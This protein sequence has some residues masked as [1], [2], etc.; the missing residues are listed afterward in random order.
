MNL[1]SKHECKCVCVSYVF[2]CLSLFSWIQDGIGIKQLTART[3]LQQIKY[4]IKISQSFLLCSYIESGLV[5]NQTR[6]HH[7]YSKQ[8]DTGID[9]MIVMVMA[10]IMYASWK[11]MILE[12]YD[13]G[14]VWSWKC[15]IIEVY[16][17]KK[18]ITGRK[19][20]LQ[21]P[22]FNFDFPCVL[23]VG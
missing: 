1:T 15:M 22:S 17:P 10:V 13:H 9:P 16:D 4:S 14:S 23:V 12:V 20:M 21:R 11:C 3:C 7:R 19:L 5:L 2:G 6:I 8:N 18:S